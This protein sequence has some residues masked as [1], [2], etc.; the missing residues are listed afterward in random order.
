MTAAPAPADGARPDVAEAFKLAMRYLASGVGII[1]AGTGENRR[2]FTA[3]AVC[4]VCADPPT[5]LVC[6]NRSAEAHDVIARHG[7]F[8]INLLAQGDAR[9]AERFAA[10]DGSKGAVRFEGR[11]W[12]DLATGAPALADALV[13][14]D[15]EVGDSFATGT[16]TVF[17]GLVSGAT[18]HPAEPLIY[19]DRTFRALA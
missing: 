18:V 5:V 16:H 13:C 4:S 15:C 2:G 10:R 1:T 3:T 6:A 7:H 12:V 8:C 19:F 14:L 17:F 11:D 9:L